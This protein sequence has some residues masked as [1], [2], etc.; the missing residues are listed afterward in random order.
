MIMVSLFQFSSSRCADKY[1]WKLYVDGSKIIL[2]LVTRTQLWNKYSHGLKQIATSVNQIDVLLK[3]INTN[4]KQ[5]DTTI[6]QIDIH[7]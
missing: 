2:Y 1:V 6:I 4:T 7:V 5:I 3:Q